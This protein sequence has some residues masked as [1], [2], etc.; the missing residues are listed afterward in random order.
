[1]NTKQILITGAAGYLGARLAKKYLAAT[2]DHI[3]LWVRARDEQEFQARSDQLNRQLNGPTDRLNYHWGDLRS[4]D[5]F[6]SIE[7]DKIG[8]IIHSAAVTRFNVDEATAE[9]VNVEGTEKMLRFASRC[10]SLEAFGLLSTVYA[11]G[12]KSGRV[13]ETVNDGKDGFANH[14]ESSKWKSEASLLRSFDHLPWRILRVATVIAD[15]DDG[16]VSQYNAFHNTLKL[17]YYGLL[18]LVPGKPETPVYFVTGDFVTDAVFTLMNT[19]SSRA[20]YH[21]AHTAKESLTLGELI[22]LAFEIFEQ[23]NDFKSRRILKPLYADSESFDLLVGGLSAFGGQIVNQAVSSVAPFGKQLF[24]RK[25]IDNRNLVSALESY[26]AP[27]ARRLIGNTC[28]YLLRTKWGR[29][30]KAQ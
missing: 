26:S 17:F 2:E 3:L 13:E 12:L 28:R 11:S 20:I 18:S 25:E 23:E 24:I 16:C 22:D 1:M 14:Y 29:D 5:P 30:V 15:S 8:R 21:V 19:D 6:L 27:D 9:G 4:D 7:P 10:R